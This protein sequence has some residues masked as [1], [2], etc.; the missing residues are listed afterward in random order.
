M[1][2]HYTTH[3][4][5]SG[6]T[7]PKYLGVGDQCVW[8]SHTSS[9]FW[10]EAR[11]KKHHIGT[12]WRLLFMLYLCCWSSARVSWLISLTPLTNIILTMLPILLLLLLLLLRRPLIIIIIEMIIMM[13]MINNNNIMFLTKFIYLF[14][15]GESLQCFCGGSKFCPEPIETCRGQ[16]D[17]C[18]SV[19]FSV[20]SSKWLWSCWAC[21][22]QSKK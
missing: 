6:K 5:Q 12:T 10:A 2:H 21:A 7:C 4:V 8:N 18:G 15:I 19:M 20:G 16:N 14:V 13:M 22:A 17:V 11:V 1:H 9:S 3:L